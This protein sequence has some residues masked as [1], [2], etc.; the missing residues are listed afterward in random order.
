MA[1]WVETDE[2]MPYAGGTRLRLWFKTI[3]WNYVT[4][5]QIAIAESQ[6]AKE[7]TFIVISH[8]IPRQD[9]FLG[10]FN[11]VVEIK[12]AEAPTPELQTAGISGA[13]IAAIIIAALTFGIFWIAKDGIEVMVEES[14][15]LADVI[16][17]TGWTSLKIA[18]ALIGILAAWKYL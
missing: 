1:T 16:E 3:G 4:A 5:L 17:T 12:K 6:L 15:K 10:R 2:N 8:S 14:E 18:A 13:Q 7:K 9:G 11:F